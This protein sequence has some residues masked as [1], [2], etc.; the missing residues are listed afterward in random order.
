MGNEWK[1]AFSGKRLTD[2]V[3]HASWSVALTD[4]LKPVTDSVYWQCWPGQSAGEAAQDGKNGKMGKRKN[5]KKQKMRMKKG[6]Y[7]TI[8][9]STS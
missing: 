7:T 2:T 8:S 1:F 3:Q 9:K 4:K 6:K 5:K